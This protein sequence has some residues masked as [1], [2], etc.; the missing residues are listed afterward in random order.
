MLLTIEKFGGTMPKIIDPLL[1]P[2]NKSQAAV[3]CRFD[4]GG[5][6]VF[7]KDAFIVT[8]TN[9]GT[10]LSIF[11]YRNGTTDTY[12][13]AWDSDV[14]AIKTPLAD[15]S[16]NRVFY[17]EGGVL[18]VTDSTLFDEGTTTNYPVD[19]LLPSPPAPT[20]VPTAAGTPTGTDPTLIETRG[21]V[22]TFIN[23]Y[24]EEGPPSPVS[25]L[26]DIYDGDTVAVSGMDTTATA[27]YDVVYKRIYRLNQN[28]SAGAQYQ[29]VDEIALATTP[30]SDTVLDSAL[31]EILPSLEWDGLPAG[32][33]GLI[34]LPNGICA[35]FVGNT[36]C[37]SV[38]YRPHAWPLS[39]QKYTD[40]PI[41]ALG[42]IGLSI[43]VLTEGIPYFVT[44]NDP[45]NM[46]MEKANAGWSCVSKRGVVEADE[47]VVYPSPEGLV[48]IGPQI[49]R[50]ITKELMTPAVWQTK[51]SPAT[52]SAYYWEG[53]Y[54]GFYGTGST[55]AGFVFDLKTGEL[56]DIDLYATAGYH[57]PYAGTL[58]LQVGANIYSFNT[59]ADLRAFNYLS[60]RY[61]FLPTA[62][63]W[64]KVL[65][66]SYP[67]TV[68]IIYPRLNYTITVHVT[69]SDPI[70]VP[71]YNLVDSCEIRIYNGTIGFAGTCTYSISP[72]SASVVYGGAEEEISVTADAGCAWTAKSNDWWIG[73]ISGISGT[74]NGTVFCLVGANTGAARIGTV[75]IAGKVFIVNQDA[76]CTYSLSL[77]SVDDV[78]YSG[79]TGSVD[80]TTILGCAWTAVSNDSWIHVTSGSSGSGDGTVDYTVDA[81][82]G[83]GRSGT[84]TIADH[85]FT[86]NQSGAP[87]G[88]G[89][90]YWRIYQNSAT[91][92]DAAGYE[93]SK[94]DIGFY[95]SYDGS[96]DSLAT[97]D[98]I[99]ASSQRSTGG[100]D[101]TTAIVGGTGYQYFAG[102]AAG[103]W[104]KVDLGSV[105]AI[106][107]ARYANYNGSPWAPTS[108]KVQYSDNGADWY[109]AAT[110]ADDASTNDQIISLTS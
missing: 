69:G 67:I 30:Y 74:G 60:K 31:G 21:Y 51:Y 46:V 110:H 36:L 27:T 84:I 64:L 104:A 105:V 109:D 99:T 9:S 32:A 19:F 5:I 73:V 45:A 61:R 92:G 20:N 102:Y 63:N 38:P 41:V 50:I 96:G 83:V 15:D 90:Q 8:P 24:G 49:N 82:T 77:S 85:T 25:N 48:A 28:A 71:K 81:N 1:L 3:N 47:F 86:V 10:L 4:E 87:A 103:E 7:N 100:Y 79:A 78:P 70:R 55:E 52:I 14:D 66:S 89:H 98:N 72:E 43:V 40:T 6:A 22:Y 58:Y 95:V 59:A 23:V 12:F 68:D 34:A 26:L 13:F 80:V 65:A 16:Y 107:S 57:D 106:G 91:R 53:C 54:V 39:Y 101:I 93:W 18:K 44:G 94:H 17:T 11:L 42:A 56:V 88:G 2:L 75:T 97:E 37:L 29:F 33:A 35:A 108:V 76:L 62:F